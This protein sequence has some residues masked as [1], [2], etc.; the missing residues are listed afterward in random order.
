MG[1][2]YKIYN[3]I[4]DKIYIGKTIFTIQERWQDHCQDY[5][6]DKNEKRPL[7]NAMKKYGLEHFHIE[8]IEFVKDIE[9]LSE[10]EIYWISYYNSY[11][12]GYNATKGGDGKSYLDYDLICSLYER[13]GTCKAVAKELK[14]DAGYVGKILKMKGIKV[15]P[16]NCSEETERKKEE[17]KKEKEERQKIKQQKEQEKQ[18][19]QNQK[20][21]KKLKT[22][23]NT[24]EAIIK[25][26]SK[27]IDMY[28]LNNNF[29]RTFNSIKEASEWCINNNMCESTVPRNVR[30]GISRCLSGKY[31]HSAKHIWRYHIN[32]I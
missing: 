29:V 6:K 4:N 3:D 15:Y 14:I 28:D 2:I 17:K 26:N 1:Y 27:K 7:Y 9:I 21:E 30:I 10:R 31:K 8:E 25:A 19:R 11:Y 22:K 18:Q 23:N 5:K 13:L 16:A 12:N 32:E 20:K 24:I